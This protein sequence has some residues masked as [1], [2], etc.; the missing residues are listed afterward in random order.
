LDISNPDDQLASLKAW[1][2]QYGK[3]LIIGVIIGAALLSG[4]NYWRLYKTRTAEAAS[5]LYEALL[6]DGQQGKVDAVVATAT[7][8]MQEYDSTPYAGKAALLLARLRFDAKDIPGAK[9]NLEWAVKNATEVSVQH[10]ARLRLGHILLEQGDADAVLALVEIKDNNGFA[11]GYQELR[12]DALLAKGDRAG[13]R[14]AY[15]A[16]IE[17]LPRESPYAHFLSMK[18]DNLGVDSK[19]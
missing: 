2:K 4:L 18:R 16:A 12:G 13:A 10:T 7:K 11:S 3:S 15:Q 14:A 6:A 5:L 17:N 19:P 1:W 9:T 8:L